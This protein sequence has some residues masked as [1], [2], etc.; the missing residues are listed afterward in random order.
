MRLIRAKLKGLNCGKV[1]NVLAKPLMDSVTSSL[2]PWISLCRNA[3]VVTNILKKS[4]GKGPRENI[5]FTYS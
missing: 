4:G 2:L 1:S 5:G 3:A